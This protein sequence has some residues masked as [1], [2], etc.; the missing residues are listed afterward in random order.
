M[1]MP[2]WPK[3]FSMESM[4]IAALLASFWRR[5]AVSCVGVPAI[6]VKGVTVASEVVISATV[7]L[8]ALLSGSDCSGGASGVAVWV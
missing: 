5:A 1:V 7:A 6:G 2:R 8:G 3:S 4:A